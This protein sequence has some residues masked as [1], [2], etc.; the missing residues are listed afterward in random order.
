LVSLSTV[1]NVG[2]AVSGK[3]SVSVRIGGLFYINYYENYE[4]D[5]VG[6]EIVRIPSY[7]SN[8]FST[9]TFQELLYE[10]L[11]AIKA[12]KAETTKKYRHTVMPLEVVCRHDKTVLT[13]TLTG[14]FPGS[15]VTVNFD[16]VLEAGKILSL[17]IHA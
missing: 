15:P 13:A 6:H 8:L 11:A 2:R 12:W 10:G 7:R 9:Q 1:S 5:I 3:W 16:F 14:D 17:E 4:N